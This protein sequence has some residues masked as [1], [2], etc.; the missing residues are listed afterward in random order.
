MARA[1]MA[2][3]IEELRG[4]TDAGNADFTIGTT[5]Y[6]A[7]DTVQARLDNH[8]TKFYDV[9]IGALPTMTPGGL[10]YQ[11]YFIGAENLES[12]TALT[13]RDW[14][15]NVV[16]S[17]SYT[18]DAKKGVLTFGTSTGGAEYLVTG[19]S[20]DLYAAAAEMWRFKAANVAKMYDFQTDNH[21]LS[22]SQ[23][24]KTFMDMA[25]EC[26]AMR[27]VNSIQIERGDSNAYGV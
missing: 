26:E 16:G 17:A 3:L 13:V 11:T 25:R 5:T 4:L 22:R 2:D 21:R 19:T 12:G 6:W 1:G 20:Y 7:D 14:A 10:T 8:K 24:T 15:G 18:L 23:M 9:E 27:A